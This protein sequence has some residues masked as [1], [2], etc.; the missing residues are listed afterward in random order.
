MSE[1]TASLSDNAFRTFLKEAKG[2]VVAVSYRVSIPNITRTDRRRGT[3]GDEST[4]SN[5]F[6]HCINAAGGV[7]TLL[8][9]TEDAS[10]YEVVLK[11]AYG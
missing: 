11:G 6:S 5:H 8:E 2:N 4:R 7:C 9:C 3:R 1:Y 10:I